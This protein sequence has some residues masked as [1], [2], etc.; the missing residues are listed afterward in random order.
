[1]FSQY[2]IT[3]FTLKSSV[4]Q[5]ILNINEETS[6]KNC[7]AAYQD[8]CNHYSGK[9][10]SLT[11][12]LIA[13]W[14]KSKDLLTFLYEL[15]PTDINDLLEI[16]NDWDETSTN[17]ESVFNLVLLKKFFDK[18]DTKIEAARK[19]KPLDVDIVVSCFEET[20]KNIEY[21]DIISS[22]ES[23]LKNLSNIKRI[24]TETGNK[25][26]SKRKRIL[27]IMETSDF[28]FNITHL[29]EKY[30]RT[31]DYQFDI[32][33]IN[34]QWQEPISFDDLSDLRDR[35]RLTQYGT[36]NNNSPQN[37]TDDHSHQFQFFISLVDTIEMILQSFTSLYEAGYPV[38]KQYLILSEIFTCEKGNYQ[39]LD[40]FNSNLQTK[41]I[42]WEKQLC[43]MY[44][45]C[46]NLTYFSHQQLTMAD[47]ALRQKTIALSTDPTYH[48]LK[49][50]GINP[51]SI[52]TKVLLNE[53]TEPSDLLETVVSIIKTDRDLS[54]YLTEEDE[55][56]NKKVLVVETTD[57]GILRA[58]FSLCHLDS[59]SPVPN[60]LFYCT[61]LTSWMEIRAF[62]Y[63]CF[64][65][66]KLHQLIRPELLSIAIQDQFTELLHQLIEQNP[67]H[68]FRLGI[69]TTVLTA[70]LYMINNFNMYHIIRIL[71]DQEM[72]KE[73][74][75]AKKIQESIGESCKLVTSELGGL[76]KS[77]YIQNKA[78]QCGKK[79]VKFP[80]S[81]DVDI[82]TLTAQLRDAKIQSQS[83]SIIIHIDI[84]PVQNVQQ[85]NEFLYCF[86][87]F[88]CF[89]L[90]QIPVCIQTDLTLFI[91]LDSSSFLSSLKDGLVILQYLNT[92]HIR[93]MNFN[94]LNYNLLPVQLVVQYL[95]AID[96]GT[97]STNNIDEKAK[98]I[99]DKATCISLLQTYFVQNKHP[100]FLSW[101][102]LKIFISVYYKLFSS[103]S[104]CAYFYAD[105]ETQS[106]LR[107]DV[108]TPLLASSDQ[109]TSLSVEKV[110]QNQRSIYSSETSVPFS[111]AIIRWDK[112]QPFTLIFTFDNEPLFI[113]KTRENVP[114][115]LTDAFR[116]YYETMNKTTAATQYQYGGLFSLFTWMSSSTGHT[117]T[118]AAEQVNS[119]FADPNQMTHEQ[120]FLQLTLLSTK[121]STY[122]SIC[123]GCYSQYEYD[124][125][126]CTKC[127]TM[128]TLIKPASKNDQEHLKK[129]QTQIAKKLQS[130]YVLTADNY[131]KMLLIYL[132]V[133]SNLPV[134]I[135]GETGKL[136]IVIFFC[137]TH[138]FV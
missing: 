42:D 81:G 134:L 32:N 76:G 61:K 31:S 2:N 102:Q 115:S 136:Y 79:C 29:G 80:I 113:Y 67:N 126:K 46:I 73:S 25:E 53:S 69:I 89:R 19:E 92:E 83:S 97:I 105:A 4:L 57:K 119:F 58:I 59:T 18:L 72:M 109:F 91:E 121:Y 37:W 41:L 124:K 128:D 63:R 36:T 68:R 11:L 107:H 44:K 130:E 70:N 108:L 118:F 8:Y 87:L 106:S 103:F 24:R 16:V 82:N 35:A 123:P 117:T 84:G 51:Q 100:Q 10:H 50:I 52:D 75:L 111:E 116:Y 7:I 39:K 22:I 99:L 85:L 62:I 125:E 78:L 30:G 94:E 43:D 66:Q 101:T 55:R 74:D 23:C 88:H 122:K 33:V 21:K 93:Q 20:L 26:Q 9:Y 131:V 49:F 13:Q 110:R 64:Y 12:E 86:V 48:L 133:Q 34:K 114:E 38:I 112:S 96:D 98:D 56:K 5:N 6:G 15:K 71:N 138:G 90:E 95:R 127:P 54:P 120:F 14:S 27:D 28:S 17:T 129:F 1:M 40:E 77:T 132:R 45:Q 65:S 3:N 135:M 60:Q 137:L 47:D 104:R